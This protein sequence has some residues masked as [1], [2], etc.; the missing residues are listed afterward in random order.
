[1]SNK[2]IYNALRRGGLSHPGACAV[3]G[4]MYCESIMKSNIVEK[5]C[6]MGDA[7]YTWNVDNGGMSKD[8]FIHDSYGYGLCQWTYW[9]R[10]A[11][12][13]DLARDKGVS[14][15]DEAMQ[16]ELCVKELRRDNGNLYG[17]LCGNCDLYTATSRVCCEYER[18][19]VNNVQPRFNAA[20][21]FYG[22]FGDDYIPDPDEGDDVPDVP[23]DIPADESCEIQV[24]VLHKGHY[25]R[26]VYLLQRGLED[27]GCNL[28][29]YG[30]DGDFGSCTEAAVK[31]FQ[32]ECGI[33]ITGIAN[34]DVWQILFQ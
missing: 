19:A 1:M 10:K 18:P 5:R 23:P 14:V 4:N 3:M 15:S 31:A 2:T 25:G 9:S 8:Q 27:A 13:Y 12:L 21:Q 30:C 28:G 33:D 24:R 7:D 16:C 11:E 26:D 22:E 32:E 34:G 6:P 17:F 20:Q 29:T